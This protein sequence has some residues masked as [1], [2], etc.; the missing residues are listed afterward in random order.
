MDLSGWQMCGDYDFTNVRQPDRHFLVVRPSL[1][2]EVC[3]ATGRVPESVNDLLPADNISVEISEDAQG[4]DA[5]MGGEKL[6]APGSSHDC[7][8]GPR[9]RGGSSSATIHKDLRDFL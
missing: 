5:M 8:L 7:G 9:G 1:A 6:Y 3:R 2:G 4:V